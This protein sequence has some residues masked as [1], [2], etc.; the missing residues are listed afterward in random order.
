MRTCQI[1][2]SVEHAASIFMQ[3]V[4]ATHEVIL[5]PLILDLSPLHTQLR[6][7]SKE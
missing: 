4:W 2:P 7:K 3:K 5:S 6:F 1:Q